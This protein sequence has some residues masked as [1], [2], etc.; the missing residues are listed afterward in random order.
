MRQGFSERWFAYPLADESIPFYHAWPGGR[1]LVIARRMQPR[2]QYCA[3]AYAAKTHPNELADTL[4]TLVSRKQVD[5][6]KTRLPRPGLSI[7]EPTVSFRPCLKS[8]RRP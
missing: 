1:C 2:L 7:N 8:R 3:N 5:C 6:P 4:L